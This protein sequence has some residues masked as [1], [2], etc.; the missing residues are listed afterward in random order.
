MDETIDVMSRRKEEE[1]MTYYM[2]IDPGNQKSG[3]ACLSYKGELV[4]KRILPTSELVAYI[5]NVVAS[6][7]LP[8]NRE[9]FDGAVMPLF[10]QSSPIH[11]DRIVCGNG[12]NH[13]YVYGELKKL[14]STYHI[15][16][17]LCD[18]AYTTE[19][20]KRLYWKYHRPRGWQRFLPKGMRVPPEPVDDFTA[21]V[22]GLRY[23]TA[24]QKNS[25]TKVP[26]GSYE[27]TMGK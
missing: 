10:D 20:A 7:S 24:R 15:D 23:V 17:V 25:K 26:H 6:Q 8:R 3:I 4:D 27:S 18:E 16:V 1:Y 12:T 14:S 9:Q 11:I 21:W 19:E 5:E 13:K 22:I 2:A